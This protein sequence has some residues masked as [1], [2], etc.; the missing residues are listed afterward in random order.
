MTKEAELKK[1]VRTLGRGL[2]PFE[3]EAEAILKE[4]S[5]LIEATEQATDNIYESDD[6]GRLEG[7][8]NLVDGISVDLGG[9]RECIAE[10]LRPGRT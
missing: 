5:E 7:L 8:G 3:K 1:R 10:F 9:I 4:A 6:L 2:R